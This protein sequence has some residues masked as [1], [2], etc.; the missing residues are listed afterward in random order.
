NLKSLNDQKGKH[1]RT[2][3]Y[4]NEVNS[5]FFQVFAFVRIYPK[6]LVWWIA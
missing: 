6:L 1:R 2:Y 3:E 5:Y 4:G